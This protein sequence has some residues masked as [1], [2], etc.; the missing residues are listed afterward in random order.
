MGFQDQLVNKIMTKRIADRLNN[1]VMEQFTDTLSVAIC[2]AGSPLPDPQRSGSCAVVI[3]GDQVVMIDAGS[4]VSQ[5][6]AM[7]ILLGLGDNVFLTHFHS[8]H[9]NSMV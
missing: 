9:I 8:D 2:G 4:G 1:V 5:V 7:G 3:A 6:S